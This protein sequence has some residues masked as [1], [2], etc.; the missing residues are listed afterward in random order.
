MP[1]RRQRGGDYRPTSTRN[2]NNGDQTTASYVR[3]YQTSSGYRPTAS[4]NYAPSPY[5]SEGYS[6]RPVVM[7]AYATTTYH[8]P[9]I[10]DKVANFFSRK[11]GK[12]DQS[13]ATGGSSK[14]PRNNKP[15]PTR[16]K[17]TQSKR[18][19]NKTR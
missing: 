16:P 19:S 6:A 5:Y 17:S 11:F 7:P 8:Q 13:A 4:H 9:G 14:S 12:K 2:Y 10:F 3:S 15:K 1:T 18:G